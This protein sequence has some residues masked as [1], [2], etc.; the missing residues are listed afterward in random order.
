MIFG[1]GSPWLSGAP[2]GRARAGYVSVLTWLAF[3]I[4]GAGQGALP[5]LAGGG[6]LV[7][8]P[9]RLCQPKPVLRSNRVRSVVVQALKDRSRP[10]V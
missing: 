10:R 6:A 5:P 1:R 3:V 2:G 4:F 9:A 8:R 7:V